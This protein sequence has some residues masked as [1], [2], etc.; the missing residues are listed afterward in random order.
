[1]LLSP[2]KNKLAMCVNK[3]LVRFSFLSR[4]SVGGGDDKTRPDFPGSAGAKVWGPASPGCGIG[5]CAK[6]PLSGMQVGCRGERGKTQGGEKKEGE[7]RGAKNAEE[8][9]VG[10]KRKSKSMVISRRTLWRLGRTG[11]KVA[12]LPRLGQK[13]EGGKRRKGRTR[14][15]KKRRKGDRISQ[16]ERKLDWVRERE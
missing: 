4:G 11:G 8:G 14:E 1:M 5:H 16:I 2:P 15:H 10:G 6:K 3:A 7:Q 9:F 12:R 13:N